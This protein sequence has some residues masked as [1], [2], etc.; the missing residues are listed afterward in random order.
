VAAFQ[1]RRDA[2]VGALRMHGMAVDSPRATMYVWLPVPGGMSEPFA[3]RAL[4]EEGVV[5][6]P[7]AAM[8][9][10]GEG[11]VRMALTQS[12]ARLE[13]AAARLARVAR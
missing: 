11:F 6:M 9:P 8:G 1:A 10:G 2:L 12:P 3:R 5:V 4:M 13:D 7:G